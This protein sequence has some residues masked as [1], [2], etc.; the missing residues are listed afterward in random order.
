[1][2]MITDMENGDQIMAGLSNDGG[3]KKEDFL[4]VLENQTSDIYKK[5]EFDR[6]VELNVQSKKVSTKPK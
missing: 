4:T 5:E 6:I 1:M 2:L 3:S